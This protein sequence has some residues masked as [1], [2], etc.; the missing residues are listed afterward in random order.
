MVADFN[1]W[2]ESTNTFT[3]IAAFTYVIGLLLWFVLWKILIGYHWFKHEKMMHVPFWGCIITFIINIF[4]ALFAEIPQYGIEI[5]IYGFV[6]KN[7]ATVAMFTLGIAVF[8]VVTFKKQAKMLSHQESRKFLQ[9]VFTSFLLSVIGVLPLYW[10]PQIWGW[11]TTL[12]HL[13]TVPFTYSLFVLA[14]AMIVYLHEI[15]KDDSPLLTALVEDDD[16]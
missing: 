11:L 2:W 5:G 15:K 16:D 14:A 9:L 13:K 1:L 6:E 8:V 7:A 12:R 10:V 3:F 4:L